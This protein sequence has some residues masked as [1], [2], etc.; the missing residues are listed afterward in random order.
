MTSFPGALPAARTF[1]L[2]GGPVLRWGIL[3]PG[4]IAKDFVHAVHTHTDQRVVAVASRSLDRA[5]A[6]AATHGIEKAYGDHAELVADPGVD[7]VYIASP[8]SEHKRL[9]LL[10]IRA[11]KHVL[12]EKPI[13]VTSADAREIQSAARSAKVFAMEGM[14]TRYLPQTD[15]MLQLVGDGVL[16]DIRLITADFATIAPTD[17]LGR[18]YNP[19]LAGGALLDL[20]I[21]PLWVSQ[22][23]L[24]A[25]RGVHTFGTLTD[26]GV[27]AQ[28][29]IVLEFDSGAQSV[30]TTSLLHFSP[31]RA[32]VNGT[33]ARIEINPWF[34]VPAGFDSGLEFRD[35]IAWEAAAVARHIADGLVDSP[36]HPL[37]FSVELMTT[38][39]T[40]RRSVGTLPRD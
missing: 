39:D 3:A 19:E 37:S 27:D 23:F 30:L 9:A 34:V 38:M 6:F 7:V 35:G 24:G 36:L 25:P 14:W 15:V 10:A 18:N 13:G 4:D 16:G 17:P 40:V 2:R 1:P 20:G 28:T 5:Q 11:G 31:E 12:V 26:T 21:Y 33:A 22:L 8:H 29:A 32:S